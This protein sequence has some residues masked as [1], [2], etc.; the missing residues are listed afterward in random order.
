VTVLGD[1]NNNL[2]LENRF[3]H[4]TNTLWLES[5]YLGIWNSSWY[6]ECYNSVSHFRFFYSL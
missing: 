6:F 3:G 4:L 5:W 2:S 1:C